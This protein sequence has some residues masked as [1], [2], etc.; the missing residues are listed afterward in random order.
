MYK[1]WA[2]DLDLYYDVKENRIVFPVEDNGKIVDAIGRA[3][4]DSVVPKWKRYGTYAEGFIRGQH[5]LAVIENQFSW[6][7]LW[8]LSPSFGRITLKLVDGQSSKLLWRHEKVIDRNTGKNTR[9]LV[10]KM[11]KQIARNFPYTK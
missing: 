11:M 10:E 9:E 4:D 3:T 8:V 1:L 5:N 2:E 6:I 7:D